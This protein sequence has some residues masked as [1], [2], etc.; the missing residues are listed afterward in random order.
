MPP[1]RLVSRGPLCV[2]MLLSEV[3]QE[4]IPSRNGDREVIVV[5]AGFCDGE[6]DRAYTVYVPIL[7]G[8]GG[9]KY[10][11]DFKCFYKFCSSEN[12]TK[13][14]QFDLQIFYPFSIL[15]FDHKKVHFKIPHQ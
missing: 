10:L 14:D 13:S 5:G 1:F 12:I 4:Q 11:E 7:G 2:P 9:E 8:L 15:L 3:E 6:G